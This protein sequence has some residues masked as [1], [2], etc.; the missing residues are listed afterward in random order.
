MTSTLEPDYGQMNEFRETLV[1]V[2]LSNETA[3]VTIT[4]E[5]MVEIQPFG[6]RDVQGDCCTST[7]MTLKRSTKGRASPDNESDTE[8]R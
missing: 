1:V 8:K 3:T 4:G 5:N 6:I 7:G 2:I